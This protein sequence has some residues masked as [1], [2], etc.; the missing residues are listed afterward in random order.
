MRF[1]DTGGQYI[2]RREVMYST[3]AF[4]GDARA[5]A[6]EGKERGGLDIK[7]LSQTVTTR[8]MLSEQHA[9][10]PEAWGLR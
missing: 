5:T 10:C 3:L 1:W 8:S 2:V 7:T 6:K 4:R 9:V